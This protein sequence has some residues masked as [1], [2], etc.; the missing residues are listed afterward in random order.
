LKAAATAADANKEIESLR[1]F[2]LSTKE[3]AN[4]KLIATKK[5]IKKSERMIERCRGIE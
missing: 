4:E 5:L 1:K 3:A 2:N